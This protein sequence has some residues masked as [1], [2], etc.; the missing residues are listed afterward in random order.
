MFKSFWNQRPHL[1]GRHMTEFTRQQEIQHVE[2]GAPHVVVLGA[3]A[4]RAAFPTGDR[5]GLRLPLMADF[6]EVIPIGEVLDPLGIPYPGRNF[7][8][9]YS[10]LSQDESKSDVC[11]QLEAVIYR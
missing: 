3:G 1:L 4:S 7:E 10:E 9:L 5:N 8:E 11:S 2:M 6:S